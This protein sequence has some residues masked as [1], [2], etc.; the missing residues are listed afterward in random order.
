MYQPSSCRRCLPLPVKGL[1][2]ADVFWQ[3]MASGKKYWLVWERPLA[4]RIMKKAFIIQRPWVSLPGPWL[5]PGCGSWS[6]DKWPRPWEWQQHRAAGC[7][8]IL[9]QTPNPCRWGW[10]QKRQWKPL[11]WLQL[12]WRPMSRFWMAYWD[13]FLFMEK[14]RKRLFLFYAG[15]GNIPGIWKKMAF[16]LKNIRFVPLLCIPW[17]QL[18]SCGKDMDS[19]LLTST[20]WN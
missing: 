12:A 10:L 13:I 1:S 19:S 8:L 17:M 9:E 20:R 16:G 6:R 3:P 2:V 7:G 4:K 14:D 11:N 15:N 18:S 5:V